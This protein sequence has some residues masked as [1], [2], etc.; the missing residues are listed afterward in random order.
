MWKNIKRVV[1]L[2]SEVVLFKLLLK[3]H[4]ALYTAVCGAYCFSYECFGCS[5]FINT[6][7][8]PVVNG[9]TEGLMLIYLAHFFTAIVGMPFFELCFLRL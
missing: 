9:P 3:S 8:L 6:L 7:I 5:Y 2:G 4:T 1:Y